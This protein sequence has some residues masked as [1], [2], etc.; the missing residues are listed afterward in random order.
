MMS[1]I[2][3]EY[4]GVFLGLLV[5]ACIFYFVISYLTSTIKAF[6]PPPCD[7]VCC[8]E[9]Y[10]VGFTAE[11]FIPMLHKIEFLVDFH[12]SHTCQ[13]DTVETFGPCLPDCKEIHPKDHGLN[14]DCIY[15]PHKPHKAG[16]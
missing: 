9:G 6:T 13:V 8:V 7:R 12:E 3:P 4:I 14:A 11:E 5:S 1:K 16:K 2:K 15:C 10:D